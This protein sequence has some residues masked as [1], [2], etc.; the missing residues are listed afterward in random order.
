MGF[1]QDAA[2][3]S[4]CRVYNIHEDCEPSGNTAENS[5]AKNT[6]LI[7]KRINLWKHI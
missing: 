2:K 1:R 6:V 7:N 3:K 4:S 5:S